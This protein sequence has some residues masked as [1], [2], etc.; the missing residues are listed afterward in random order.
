[1]LKI[2]VAHQDE[3]DGR[4][5]AAGDRVPETLFSVG[6]L[7]LQDAAANW[8]LHLYSAANRMERQGTGNRDY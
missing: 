3:A 6:V 1:M 2:L 7:L 5:A 4:P 8:E